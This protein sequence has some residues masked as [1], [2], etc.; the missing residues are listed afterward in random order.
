MIPS[1]GACD[2]W[3]GAG[4]I[5]GEEG[6]GA[7]R[8]GGSP[9]PKPTYG[10]RKITNATE[11]SPTG[12]DEL[13]FYE[14]D[15][16]IEPT[17]GIRKKTNATETSP[18]GVDEL[19][20]SNEVD[21]G[22]S[23]DTDDFV[24]CDDW[25]GGDDVM[26]NDD[27]GS[28]MSSRIE[29]FGPMKIH[30]TALFRT[31]AVRG[32]RREI[33]MRRDVRNRNTTPS[34]MPSQY[35]ELTGGP[36]HESH[37]I[38]SSNC[39][40]SDRGRSQS[41]SYLDSDPVDRQ[42]LVQREQSAEGGA[43][44][45]RFEMAIDDRS[46]EGTG[47]H[48]SL[49]SF[50]QVYTTVT[51]SSGAETTED[52]ESAERDSPGDYFDASLKVGA[53]EAGTKVSKGGKSPTDVVDREYSLG[54]LRGNKPWERQD[55]D[56][57]SD[58]CG[59]ELETVPSELSM[60]SLGDVQVDRSASP[61]SSV[62]DGITLED[63]D[64]P[65]PA[66]ENF[67]SLRNFWVH[68]WRGLAVTKEPSPSKVAVS[69]DSDQPR[70]LLKEDVGNTMCD[71]N[72]SVEDVSSSPTARVAAP[73]NNICID[74]DGNQYLKIYDLNSGDN[75]YEVIEQRSYELETVEE[76]SCEE[77]D[78]EEKHQMVGDTREGGNVS[79]GP[80]SNLL[81]S[82]LEKT[83]E[84]EMKKADSDQSYAS[85]KDLHSLFDTYQVILKP[86]HQNVTAVKSP[87]A[88]LA[89]SRSVKPPKKLRIHTP[90]YIIDRTNR[91]EMQYRQAIL[92]REKLDNSVTDVDVSLQTSQKSSDNLV[93]QELNVS[94]IQESGRPLSEA[95]TN[96][97][98]SEDYSTVTETPKAFRLVERKSLYA[99]F[100][101]KE[102]NDDRSE[103]II[104]KE[105][106]DVVNDISLDIDDASSSVQ[107]SVPS[108]SVTSA[109]TTNEQLV[110]YASN[111][112]PL[113][114]FTPSVA[115]SSVS[116]DSFALEDNTNDEDRPTKSNTGTNSTLMKL[117][118]ENA[119]L[120]E[121][122]AATQR[123]LA[124]TQWKL[125]M[126]ASEIEDMIATTRYEL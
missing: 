1:L 41:S 73:D 13:Q 108:V 63:K 62:P 99:S 16:P 59:S 45:P 7:A 106:G 65:C 6:R 124:I 40:E 103:P 14:E 81:N 105:T 75:I 10:S 35:P 77:D 102:T 2:E 22:G 94:S 79:N 26:S 93:P 58:S 46:D 120:A 67:S 30:E 126:A 64:K 32:A 43:M 123:E 53:I 27:G 87:P 34:S 51:D 55:G 97:E 100:T 20:D 36:R 44:P 72:V 61:S 109:A 115:L 110:K 31:G 96:V 117:Y 86:D 91:L 52:S 28:S 23:Q 80:M 89:P 92:P 116:V 39:M 111:G 69:R 42:S 78:E 88:D 25:Y 12:V 8:V 33:E 50:H 119:E 71:D 38:E 85:L 47:S 56:L 54:Y 98:D 18:T 49:G 57:E 118:E 74:R 11:A 112:G 66:K 113:S 4:H 104:M 114:E 5:R 17:Y 125:R 84:S 90:K 19:Q 82:L 3:S 83:V 21:L 76:Q 121:T 68:E 101:K 70:F 95:L 48:E 122:L 60:L 107:S 24:A 29:S 37:L 9:P 15:G